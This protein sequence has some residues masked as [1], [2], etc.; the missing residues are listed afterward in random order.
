MKT[1]PDIHKAYGS[2][3]RFRQHKRQEVATV[4]DALRWLVWCSEHTPA[5]SDIRDMQIL[6]DRI[7]MDL[8][9]KRWGK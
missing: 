4:Q 2:M 1:H 8:S 5:A 9:Q 6:L 7:Q 3:R